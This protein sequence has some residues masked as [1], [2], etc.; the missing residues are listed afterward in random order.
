[1]DLRAWCLKELDVDIPAM[2]ILG[3]V[4]LNELAEELLK[5]VSSNGEGKEKHSSQKD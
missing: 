1:M 5:A 2:H 3:G 4:S